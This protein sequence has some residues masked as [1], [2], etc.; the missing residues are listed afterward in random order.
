MKTA[1]QL[2]DEYLCEKLNVPLTEDPIEDAKLNVYA[3][4][5]NLIGELLAKEKAQIVEAYN[6][7]Y[8]DGEHD[9]KHT[10]NEHDIA[11]FDNAENYYNE[12]FTQIEPNF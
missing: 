9:E 7:G 8:R 3:E 6:Q 1:I 10:S 2:I 12:T 4:I 5:G 11:I